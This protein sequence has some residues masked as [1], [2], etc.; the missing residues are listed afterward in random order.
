MNTEVIRSLDYDRFRWAQDL[1]AHRDYRSAALI[2]AALVTDAEADGMPGLTEARL[3]LAR[4]YYHSAQLNRAEATARRVLED[5][6]SEPY[7]ALLLA[8][9]L[10][11]RSDP[12]AAS[13][14]R[15]ATALGAPGLTGS[16]A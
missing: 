1:F 3:L 13:A 16:A 8:R 9:T 6:P 11:R 12:A 7:A 15:L 5:D 14:G 4:A 10:E 2:L